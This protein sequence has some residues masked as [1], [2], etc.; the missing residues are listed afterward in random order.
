M[1]EKFYIILNVKTD[2]GLESFGRFFIGNDRD[3]AYSLFQKLDGNS[4]ADEKNVLFMELM[5]V[6]NELPFNVKIIACTL[7]QI[8]ANCRVITREMFKIF[9]LSES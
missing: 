3:I 9:N 7:D 4:D 1:R 6:K 8:T 5:E 2:S